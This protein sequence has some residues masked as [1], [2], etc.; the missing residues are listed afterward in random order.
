[1]HAY[2]RQQL[3]M[4]THAHQYELP[5]QRLLGSSCSLGANLIISS[6]LRMVMAASVANLRLLIL[7]IAGSSTPAFRLFLT[8]PLIRS[9]PE[10]L[11]SCLYSSS[12]L[13]AALWKTLSFA[14]RSVASLAALIARVFGM[15]WRASENS[16]IASC[17]LVPRVL[18]KS[19]R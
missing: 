3:L 12:A 14:M 11:S 18:A 8:F 1:M 13:R 5:T 17:S 7:E 2:I 9:S 15:I 6:I 16:A 10:Y 19:S 4:S